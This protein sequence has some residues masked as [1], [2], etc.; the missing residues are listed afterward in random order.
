[1]KSGLKP[2][3]GIIILQV[4]IWTALLISPYLASTAKNG[5]I[6]EGIPTSF[7]TAIGVVNIAL[8]YIHAYVV[9]P[10]F[11]NRRKWWVYILVSVLLIFGSFQLKWLV[12]VLWYADVAKIVSS[13]RYIFPSSIVFFIF[14]F[15]YRLTIDRLRIE[16][17][18]KEK[19][20]A[21]LLTELKFLRSQISPH[22]LFNVLTNLVSLARKKSDNLEPALIKLADL[23][24]YMLYDTQG[25]KVPLTTEIE[26]LNNY[27]DLQKLRF[28]NDVDIDSR[29]EAD[30][31]TLDYTI[32]PML[33][34]PFVENAFKHG[35]GYSGRP[36]ILLRISVA[37]ETLLFEVRNTFEAEP[38]NT[39]DESSGIGLGNVV[40]RLNLLYRNKYTLTMND[41]N[42]LFHII[43]TLKLL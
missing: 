16:R 4:L 41:A 26:Y 17:E 28:G 14:S 33:L 7:Y 9:Y 15:F 43:L 37:Y 36:A 1:M 35:V 23:L 12:L 40:S 21:Q 13:Y 5:H 3:Y 18:Q 8:F 30:E 11:F 32:E 38:E 27:L 19:Q 39:K 6:I 2:K 10:A 29:I 24:R 34:I 25:K 20:A 22:F 42:N 31:G